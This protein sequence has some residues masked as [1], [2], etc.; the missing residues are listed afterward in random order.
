MLQIVYL[1][2]MGQHCQATDSRYQLDHFLRRHLVALHVSRGLAADVSVEGLLQ[3]G[4]IAFLEH[5]LSNM[6]SP[7][8]ATVGDVLYAVPFN[9]DI[10]RGQ[11][12]DHLLGA[13][14]SGVAKGCQPD[15][16][17]RVGIVDE[18]AQDMD[19]TVRNIGADLDSRDQ[20]QR[21][22]A[23]GNSQRRGYSIHRV[24]IGDGDNCQA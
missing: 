23:L 9:M 15:D 19:F 6:W 3:R 13:N 22:I 2:W 24:V 21:R 1:G 12:V 7:H 18:V 10:H 5:G 11:F 17:V 20:P 14:L 16:K 8:R 4:D